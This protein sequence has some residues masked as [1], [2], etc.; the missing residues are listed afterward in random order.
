M[1]SAFSQVRR[2]WRRFAVNWRPFATWLLF[3]EVINCLLLWP[4]RYLITFLQQAGAIPFVSAASLG[5]LLV[6]RPL[7]VGGALLVSLA[8]LVLA[9][10]EFLFLWQVLSGQ[11]RPIRGR[12][13]ASSTL[14]L[15]T[16]GLTLLP[17]AQFFLKTPFLSQVNL[18]LVAS[19]YLTR[20]PWLPYLAA[21]AWLILLVCWLVLTRALPLVL[22]NDLSLGFALRRARQQPGRGRALALLLV[23]GTLVGGAGFDL[24]YLIQ[25]AADLLP[26]P[27]P[28]LVASLT[29]PLVQVVGLTLAILVGGVGL[30]VIQ[31]ASRR[32]LRASTGR[33]LGWFLALAAA[34]ALTINNSQT[35]QELS[36]FPRVQTI[37][38]RGVAGKN[39][40]Q[41][42]LPALINTSKTYHPDYVEFDV[43]ETKDHRFVVVHDENLK[44]LTGVNKTP[45]QLTLA[46]LT[47]LTARE[48]GHAA[49]LVSL[50]RYLAVANR[51]HQR[52][53]VEIKTTPQDSKGM[54]ARF[55]RK[56]GRELL[57]HHDLVH[58][59]DYRVVTRLH[60]LNP[61]L[62]ILAIQPYNFGLPNRAASG[63]TMEYSTLNALFIRRAHHEGKPVFAWT[64]NSAA[65]MHELLTE[66]VDGIVTD[67]LPLLLRQLRAFRHERSYAD[68]LLDLVF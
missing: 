6:H 21:I 17:V 2:A 66:H 49:K 26:T 29:F 30:T 36:R 20:L 38:H 43:H 27:W 25:R 22:D 32:P 9:S 54:L 3:F 24:L 44:K 19:D 1:L 59:M 58:S 52:V 40:V 33:R 8:A 31:N 4:G 42:T 61:R 13:L 41:N 39:G 55:N 65:A 57:T 23:G 35:H 47:R 5:W 15:L 46:Q 48:N 7:V 34:L 10:G 64:I 50:D 62:K 37:A 51:L 11:R 16:G 18:P 68:R 60:R 12:Q 14:F 63:Y 56:Y 45:H 67:R 28:R 53:I